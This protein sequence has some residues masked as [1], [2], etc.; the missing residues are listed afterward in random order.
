MSEVDEGKLQVESDVTIG[1]F[2]LEHTRLIPVANDDDVKLDLTIGDEDGFKFTIVLAF[3][4]DHI[5]KSPNISY[6]SDP[7]NGVITVTLKNFSFPYCELTDSLAT[8]K[9]KVADIND[10]EIYI[11]FVVFL[12]KDMSNSILIVFNMYSK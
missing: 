7:E 6:S 12:L 10:K 3:E 9:V 1:E 5:N 11:S 8:K 4:T 2:F